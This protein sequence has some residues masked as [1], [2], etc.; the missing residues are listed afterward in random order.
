MPPRPTPLKLPGPLQ[1]WLEQAARAQLVAGGGAPFDFATPVGEPALAAA[2]SVSWQVFRNPVSLLIGGISAV[3]LELAEPR[4]RAGVWE[5]TSFR[6]DPVGR[7]QRTGLAAMVTVY[8]AHSKAEGM[9]ASVRR[10][11]DRVHGETAAGL[12][13]RASDPELLCWVQATAAYGFLQAY[14]SFVRPLGTAERD[15]YYGEGEPA[16][17][18]YGAVGVPVTEGGV[19]VL[20]HRTYGSLEGS[21]VIFEFLDV[22]GRAELLPRAAR[23]L[24]RMLIRGAVEI[25]PAAVRAILGLGPAFGLRRWERAVLRRLGRVADR[26][27]VESSPPVQ[28]CR[29]LGLPA[30]YLFRGGQ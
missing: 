24:Q 9:I 16:S 5:H 8:G 21:D 4:V 3:I 18:L 19:E 25:T 20:F 23:P 11:H 12:A 6:R 22:L 2:D 15:R 1:G 29:R 14:Q 17:H 10:I 26:I 30:D 7:M 27:L 28:A 13:Y